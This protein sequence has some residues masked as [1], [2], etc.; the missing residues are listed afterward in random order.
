MINFH[1]VFTFKNF[2]TYIIHE[3]KNTRLWA[4]E[5]CLTS[6]LFSSCRLIDVYSQ[7]PLRVLHLLLERSQEYH[8]QFACCEMSAT[9]KL[10]YLITVKSVLNEKLTEW[11]GWKTREVQ[12]CDAFSTACCALKPKV[13]DPMTVSELCSALSYRENA[14]RRVD[15]LIHSQWKPSNKVSDEKR[16][17]SFSQTMVMFIASEGLNPLLY[18]QNIVLIR[19]MKGLPS[20]YIHAQWSCSKQG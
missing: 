6:N 5:K 12:V 2:S 20:K 19:L 1:W 8:Q 10:L 15:V 13:Y 17:V 4:V 3:F 14:W 7:P 9:L 16:P 18:L 11:T